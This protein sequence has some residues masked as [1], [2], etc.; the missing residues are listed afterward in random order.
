MT[1]SNRCNWEKQELLLEQFLFI[2]H[3]LIILVLC[4]PYRASWCNKYFVML[5]C[6][7]KY[8]IR[9]L[10]RNEEGGRV[11]GNLTV[12]PGSLKI[13]VGVKFFLFGTKSWRD[14]MVVVL[15]V[16]RVWWGA[17]DI[18]IGGTCIN[19]RVLVAEE[20]V[21]YGWKCMV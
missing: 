14:G 3:N 8:I 21:A 12:N 5:W 9:I 7:W 18:R 20:A 16:I 13:Y 1:Y 11:Q 4:K 2:S 10:R 6:I 19:D 17:T 15:E